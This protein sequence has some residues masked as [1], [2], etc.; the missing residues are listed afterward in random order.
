MSD[1]RRLAERLSET[2]VPGEDDAAERAWDLIQDAYAEREPLPRS[3][4]PGRRIALGLAGG[5]AMVA[6]GLSPAGAEVRDFV[7]DVIGID[8]EQTKPALRSLPAAGE[9]LVG[10]EHGPWVVREDGS[11]RLLG[12]Y[13][14][15]SW[16]PNGLFLAVTDGRELIAVDPEG[17]PRWSID[18]PAS[19]HDPRW[20]GSD[21]DTRIAYRS[22]GD[23]WVVAGDGTGARRVARDVA[24]LAPAW[25]PLAPET[26][27]GAP[28]VHALTYAT[29]DMR[30]HTIDADTGQRLRSP[31]SDAERIST[32]AA[33]QSIGP[34]TSPGGRS[35]AAILPAKGGNRLVVR[36]DGGGR[37]V[38]FSA[39]GRLTGPTWSPDARWLLVGWPEAD[40]W[41]FTRAE[42]PHRIVAIDNISA[43]FDPGGD[44]SGPFPRPLGWILPE[45]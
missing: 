4:R 2:P 28:P 45:R 42:R 13:D 15:A 5:A 30:I 36:R 39:R 38:L 16:S 31:P 12:D 35:L 32:P 44:G 19:V 29:E 25:R 7:S 23:L 11:K 1:D 43:E 18:A 3:S 24:P 34:A 26:K 40:Q 9:L 6:I 14:E 33:G 21:V 8:E 10:S 37:Q 20:G 22:G 27:L 17:N 41:L